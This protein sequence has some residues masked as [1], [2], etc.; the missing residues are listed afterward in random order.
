MNKD[1]KTFRRNPESFGAENGTQTRDP[2]LGRLVLY[3]LSYFRICFFLRCKGIPFHTF[4]Q[5]FLNDFS[6]QSLKKRF[7]D[8]VNAIICFLMSL[9][10]SLWRNN[11][12]SE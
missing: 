6:V 9:F 3:Q 8:I 1:K 2:Q 10:L 5:L 4:M 7:S 12:E 11:H